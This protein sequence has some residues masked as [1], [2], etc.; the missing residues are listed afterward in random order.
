MVKY[1]ISGGH[2]LTAV[3]SGGAVS[4]GIPNY[5]TSILASTAAGEWAMSAPVAGVRK[6]IIALPATSGT[7]R[8]VKLSTTSSGDSITI[9]GNTGDAV[10]NEINFNS[11]GLMSIE[12]VGVSA[13]QWKV[14][15]ASSGIGAAITTGIAYQTS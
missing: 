5:G 2:P 6:T 15:N 1:R 11:T 13:T 4:G 14:L 8:V 3:T 10:S 12:M 7:A 9:L